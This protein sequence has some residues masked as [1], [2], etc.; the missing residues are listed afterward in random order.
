MKESLAIPGNILVETVCLIILG[1][2]RG[3]KSDRILIPEA[4]G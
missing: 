4:A 2:V 1:V 3:S